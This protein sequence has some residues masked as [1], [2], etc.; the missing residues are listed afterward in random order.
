[1]HGSSNAPC[2]AATTQDER[3]AL[4]DIAAGVGPFDI[5][6]TVLAASI[7]MEHPPKGRST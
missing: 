3:I 4:G 5:L 1:V 2:F 7:A 6:D